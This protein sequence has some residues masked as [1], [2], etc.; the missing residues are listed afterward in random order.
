[1]VAVSLAESLAYWR[2]RAGAAES[3]ETQDPIAAAH[4]ITLIVQNE[5]ISAVETWLTKTHPELV[6]S[7]GRTAWGELLHQLGR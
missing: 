1:M 5:D 2:K 7:S 6:T 3:R 4:E